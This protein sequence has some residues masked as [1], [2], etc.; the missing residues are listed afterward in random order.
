MSGIRLR[1]FS[2]GAGTQSTALMV[3]IKN[4]PEL[5]TNAGLEL[6]EKAY[7]ADTGAEGVTVHKHLEALKACGLPIPLETVQHG[8]GIN[9]PH[10][11]SCMPLFVRN[12]DGSTG[13]T[14]RSCTDRYKIRPLEKAMRRDA[15][16]TKGQ[17]GIPGSITL[18]F[19]I[20]TDEATR[21]KPNQN[22]AITNVWP[23]LEI[24]WS[25]RDC[26][27]YVEAQI[28]WKPP[29][30]RC[31]TCPYIAPSDWI[32]IQDQAPEDWA[33]AVEIDRAMRGMEL[34]LTGTPFVHRLTLPLPEAVALW[35]YRRYAKRATLGAALFEEWEMD[36]MENECTGTCGL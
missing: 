31:V 10:G 36:P 30:S 20:S 1:A 27:D 25:R 2:F 13:Q 26:I 11:L 3:A 32:A 18:W 16:Y 24:G 14:H 34:K 5:F 33:E 35:R 21:Q 29:K 22:R 12:A 7:F 23:L 17:P 8:D 4:N 15:G 19:G 9:T 28:G 6:P